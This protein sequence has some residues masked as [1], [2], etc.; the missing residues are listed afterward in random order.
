M[1]IFRLLKEHVGAHPNIVAIEDVFFDEPPFYI[2]MEYVQGDNLS[3]WCETK[4]GPAAVP[5]ETP[6]DIVVQIAAALQAAHESGVIH[7]DVK[8]QNILIEEAN[9]SPQAKLTDFGIGKVVSQEVLAGMTRLGF[10]QTLESTGSQSGTQMYMAPEIIA[11]QPSTT[12]SDIYS[13]GVVLYQFLIGDFSRPLTT[14]WEEEVGDPLLRDDLRHCFARD[15]NKRFAAAKQLG[16][17]LR[18]LPERRAALAS[19]Q[20]A[21]AARE[22]AAYRR[23]VIRTAAVALLI[24]GIVAGLAFFALIQA[25]RATRARDEARDTLS[26]SDFSKS[27]VQPTTVRDSDALAQLVRSLSFNPNNEA[28]G[29]YL[30]TLLTDRSFN[31]V[32]LRLRHDGQL[33]WAEFSPDWQDAIVTA[34]ADKTARVWDAQTG[35]QLTEPLQHEA[36]FIRHSLVPTEHGS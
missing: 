36:T 29:S 2:V 7:R 6:L 17:N 32:T 25:R 30:L 31:F 15:P 23:G 14:D 33:W 8:P 18:S 20:A 10:T 35:K 26:Q 22:R 1:T 16:D 34:S 28:A 9:G 19:Q 11:G 12:R 4:G 27:F 13:L 5:G 24:L 21:V 3:G